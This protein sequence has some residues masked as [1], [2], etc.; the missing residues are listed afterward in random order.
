VLAIFLALNGRDAS[1]VRDANQAGRAGRFDEA[2]KTAARVTRAPAD[3]RALLAEARAQ[4]AA[5]R[6]APADAAWAAVARRD[7]NNWRVHYEWA[8]ALGSL[9]GDRAKAARVYARARELNP[10]LP[11]LG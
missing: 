11:A 1:L 7:P 4:T 3:T 2:V 10:R 8:R 9:G 6:L 5:R